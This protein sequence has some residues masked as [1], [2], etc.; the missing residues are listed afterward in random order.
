LF[1]LPGMVTA[2]GAVLVRGTMYPRFYFFLIGFAV[3]ILVRGVI[4]APEWVL[5]HWPRRSPKIYPGLVPALTAVLAAVLL[6]ASV[7][8][9]TRNYR[10]PKQD[11]EGAMHFVDA[12]RKD[13]ET[14]VT[15]G[16]AT[17]PFRQYYAKPWETVETVEKLQELCRQG[18]AV[19]LV[20][21]FPR[22]LEL[23]APAIMEMI[24]KQFTLIRVF[25]GTLGDGDVFVG[26]FQPR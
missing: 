25:H 19:W 3:L 17:Y 10:Y 11:F 4:V 9:L 18:R 21:T 20:Y 26:R 12:E 7:L 6:A 2:L 24:Q 13:G 5:A 15:V 23:G 16:A 8:S 22:Y 1:A 14:V